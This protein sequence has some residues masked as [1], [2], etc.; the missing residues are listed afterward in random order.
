MSSVVRPSAGR[1][2]TASRTGTY[3][4]AASRLALQAPQRRPDEEQEAGDGGERVA[5]QP[6]DERP[7][8]RPN[9]SG[10]PGLSRTRQNTSSHAARLQR[11]L[12][13]VVRPDRDAARDEQHVAVQRGLDGGARRR[14][15][16]R[17]DRVQ[18][19]LGAGA[20]GQHAAA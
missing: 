9:H 18:D 5:G 4:G 17:H 15:V 13:V 8:R 6:E 1:A 12:D 14:A 11:G 16:V 3:G 2:A 19:D 10:L 20:L 7:P